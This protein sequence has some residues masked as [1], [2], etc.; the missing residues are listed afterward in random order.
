LD[1]TFLPAGGEDH[2]RTL[3]ARRRGRSRYPKVEGTRTRAGR[4]IG[5]YVGQVLRAATRDE[6]VCLTL[7]KVTNLLAPRNTG[8]GR[9]TEAA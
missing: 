3:A 8:G 5:W 2:R 6:R 7:M 1:I 9:A 4:I